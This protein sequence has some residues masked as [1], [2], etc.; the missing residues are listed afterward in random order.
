MH[1]ADSRTFPSESQV[2]LQLADDC[3]TSR[4]HRNVL[5]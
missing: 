2:T 3:A 5:F 1:D 4:R